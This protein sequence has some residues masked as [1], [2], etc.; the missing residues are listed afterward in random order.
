MR[1]CAACRALVDDTVDVCPSCGHPQRA[2][3]A[4]LI[5][6]VPG[7]HP[8]DAQADRTS[9]IDAQPTP[10]ASAS[11]RFVPPVAA[12][13]AAPGTAGTAGAAPVPRQPPLAGQAGYLGHVPIPAGGPGAGGGPGDGTPARVRP[14][15][16]G[17]GQ[18]GVGDPSGDIGW[19]WP[20]G[21][22]PP[23]PAA[24]RF[25]RPSCAGAAATV[26]VAAAAV[27]PLGLRV[28]ARAVAAHAG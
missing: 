13:A 22:P 15:G 2:A 11:A 26:I 14:V 7:F 16:A 28:A 8:A 10:D 1:A 19:T 5:T 4:P 12:P 21:S 3:D 27:V 6:S 9:A 23:V 24:G 18:D 20:E 25:T 17:S